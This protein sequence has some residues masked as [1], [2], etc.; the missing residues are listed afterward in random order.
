[1]KSPRCIA[2]MTISFHTPYWKSKEVK[3]V[4]S[5]PY[6][7][8]FLVLWGSVHATRGKGNCQARYKPWNLQWRPACTMHHCSGGAFAVGVTNHCLTGVTA[9]CRGWDAC[10]ILPR[11]PR[12]CDKIGQRPGKPGNIVLL[13]DCSVKRTPKD[14]CLHSSVCL[15]LPSSEKLPSAVN[16]SKYRGS[17]LGHV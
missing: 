10:L 5:S 14:V 1:M 3:L 12:T 16:G 11:W 6:S 13:K 4:P 8:V 2:A 15:T 9:H 17:Q 7:I